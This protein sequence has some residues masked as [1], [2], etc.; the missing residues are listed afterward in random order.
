MSDDTTTIE[1]GEAV[2]DESG[3]ELGV[4]AAVRASEVTVSLDDGVAVD[5][6]GKRAVE[7]EASD[8]G[9]EFG[10]GYVVWRCEECGTVGELDDGLPDE[11]PSCGSDEVTKQRED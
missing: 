7:T 1:T 4:V 2:Y 11:C 9:Q 6:N 8:P 10:E 3:S 5:E